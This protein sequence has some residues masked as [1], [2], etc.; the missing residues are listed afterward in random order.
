[1]VPT[2]VIDDEADQ[3]SINGDGTL[4]TVVSA[5]VTTA[6]GAAVGDGAEVVFSLASPVPGV[7]IISPV[8]VGNEV[9]CTLD[10]TVVPQPDV[11][12]TT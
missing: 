11:L 3:A 12:I 2:L 4:S 8:T 6:T 9:P 1:M 10:F 5:L 7:S